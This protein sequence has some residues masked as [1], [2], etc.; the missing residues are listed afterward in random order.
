MKLK[1]N[2]FGWAMFGL[3]AFAGL[4]GAQD[5]AAAA[6]PP[7][8]TGDTAWMLIAT[9]LVLLMLPGLAMF[10]GGLARTK[11]VVG[12][13]MH[14]FVCMAIVGVLWVIF[15]YGLFWGDSIGG[16][17][18]W[19][20]D[21]LFL[22]GVDGTNEGDIPAFAFVA[23]QCMF[24][25]ITPA[26]ISGACAERVYF[27]GWC[28]FVV[29]WTVLVYIPLAHWIWNGDGWLFNLGVVDLAGGLVIHVSA[30]ISALVLAIL[31]GKRI[32]HPQ[33][34]VFPNNLVMTLIGAGLLWMGWF[35][36]N[37]GSTLGAGHGAARVLANTLFSACA[38]ALVWLII[39]GILFKKASGLGFA[40]GVLAG[41]VVITP[42]AAVVGPFGALCLGALS[43][44]ACYIALQ[45]KDKLGY[46]DSLDCFGI[47]GI[48]SGL[49]VIL[50]VFFALPGEE[51]SLKAQLI[52]MGATIALAGIMT[53][54][55]YYIVTFTVGFRLPADK[56]KAGMDSTLH[57]EQG[58]GFLNLN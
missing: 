40:S 10:Y 53:V 31:L 6:P 55:I 43:S 33:N 56:E 1:R 35:G 13:M 42:A 49:G 2:T 39:E 24:A 32:G 22:K 58:Y 15:G 44:V 16:F 48:G 9:G 47:H 23:F 17:I 30:G 37:A 57:G 41:L 52:G 50:L 11:N 54:I 21:F 18:G 45:A 4:A 20:P 5:A 12:T 3:L 26:L 34:T 19:N 8:D 28:L 14:T 27:R 46:D 51:V 25:I 38:G 29:L 36:F 7:I